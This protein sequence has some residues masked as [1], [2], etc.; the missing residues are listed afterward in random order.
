MQETANKGVRQPSIANDV[1][2]ESLTNMRTVNALKTLTLGNLQGSTYGRARAPWQATATSR[3]RSYSPVMANSYEPSDFGFV[4]PF[5]S[6]RP[7][8]RA[9]SSARLAQTCCLLAHPQRV[10]ATLRVANPLWAARGVY[11]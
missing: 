10:V 11:S 7:R 3:H 5:K 1:T 4:R 9:A 6:L 8:V 2:A